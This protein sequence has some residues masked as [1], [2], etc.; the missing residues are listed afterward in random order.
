MAQWWFDK[1]DFIETHRW[2]E[3]IESTIR[4]MSGLTREK[5]LEGALLRAKSRIIQPV[6]AKPGIS[7]TELLRSVEGTTHENDEALGCLIDDGDIRCERQGRVRRY[8]PMVPT[9]R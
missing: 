4:E 6:L 9:Q 7:H 3:S 8:F 2:A 1:S 5:E